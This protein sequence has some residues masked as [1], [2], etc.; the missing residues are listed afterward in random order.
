[1][2]CLAI[3]AASV[4]YAL[5]TRP[6]TDTDGALEGTIYVDDKP[7]EEG[8]VEFHSEEKTTQGPS[9]R[10]PAIVRHTYHAKT[11]GD[12]RYHVEHLKAGLLYIVAVRPQGKEKDEPLKLPG[13]DPPTVKVEPG[14][15]TF[16]LHLKA[17]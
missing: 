3:L 6:T 1:M 8:S 9:G 2:L 5:Y 11:G 4:G 15:R 14:K 12:G 17:P 10:G 7:L 16:D 13:G